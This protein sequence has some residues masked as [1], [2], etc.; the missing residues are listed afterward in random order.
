MLMTAPADVA[1]HFRDVKA[2]EP[3]GPYKVAVAGESGQ[4]L[5]LRLEGWAVSG[6]GTKD[7]NDIDTDSSKAPITVLIFLQ[8][9]HIHMDIGNSKNYL[10]TNYLGKLAVKLLSNFNYFIFGY[11]NPINTFSDN[12]NN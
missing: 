12:Y 7:A 9:Y 11:F 6:N 3:L 2:I 4:V 8:Q 1:K 10:G 5:L